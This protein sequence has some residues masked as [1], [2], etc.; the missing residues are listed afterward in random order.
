MH[1]AIQ[2][3]L[4]NVRYSVPQGGYFFWLHLPEGTDAKELRK[5][6]GSFNVDFRPGALFSSRDGLRD[7]IRL[8]FVHYQEDKIEEGILRLRQCLENNRS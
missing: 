3:H 7:Q 2:E 8:C 4:L 1:S 6:A 5:S